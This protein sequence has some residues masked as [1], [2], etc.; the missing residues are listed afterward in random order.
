MYAL[1]SN[2]DDN[3]FSWDIQCRQGSLPILTSPAQRGN[4]YFNA[5][6]SFV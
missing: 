3:G 2:L 6:P 5:V 4:A 1:T